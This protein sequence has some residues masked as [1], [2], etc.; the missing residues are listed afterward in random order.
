M[1]GSSPVPSFRLFFQVPQRLLG[2]NWIQRGLLVTTVAEKGGNLV[3]DAFFFFFFYRWIGCFLCCHLCV[4]TCTHVYC[5][6]SPSS[7]RI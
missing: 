7:L 6:D 1:A 3:V 5:S 2:L 4:L